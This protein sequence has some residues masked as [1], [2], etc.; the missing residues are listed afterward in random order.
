MILL[1]LIFIL[2]ASLSKVYDIGTRHVDHTYYIPLD[3]DGS[4][5]IR[6]NDSIA[7]PSHGGAS[8]VNITELNMKNNCTTFL[9][10]DYS[11]VCVCYD[12]MYILSKSN[13]YSRSN[14]MKIPSSAKSV[15]SFVSHASMSDSVILVIRNH[16]SN[17]HHM[18]YVNTFDTTFYMLDE[19]M[20]LGIDISYLARIMYVE[21][22]LGSPFLLL[23]DSPSLVSRVHDTFT[24]SSCVYFAPV[25][26]LGEMR[27]PMW[28]RWCMLEEKE[29][30][31]TIGSVVFLIDRLFFFY[32]LEGEEMLVSYARVSG[33]LNSI[34]FDNVQSVITMWGNDV[35]EEEKNKKT[36]NFQVFQIGDDGVILMHFSDMSSFIVCKITLMGDQPALIEAC[37]SKVFS[38]VQDYSQHTILDVSQSA[39]LESYVYFNIEVKDILTRETVS[40][41]HYRYS[42]SSFDV[43]LV[44]SWLI[45][46]KGHMIHLSKAG[47]LSMSC[48]KGRYIETYDSVHKFLKIDLSRISPLGTGRRV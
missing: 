37:S 28:K 30:R 42:R 13:Y 16:T 32:H 36:K 10:F 48:I 3:T 43:S 17:T 35:S 40:S 41:S 21:L 29:K 15:G 46:A 4:K 26:I 22:S 1:C 39:S 33:H 8:A 14:Y 2:G 20:L 27:D 47:K 19:N 9:E 24:G 38:G 25:S 44:H 11:I 7:V 18:M 5:Y 6:T 12:E 23:F 31:V 34:M 45:P